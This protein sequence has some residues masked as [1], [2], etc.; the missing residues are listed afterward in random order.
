MEGEIIMTTLT[1]K[2]TMSYTNTHK[3]GLWT[4]FKNYL[5]ENQEIITAGMAVTNG[6]SFYTYSRLLNR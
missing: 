1:A 6:T 2:T 4:R 3:E 5:A